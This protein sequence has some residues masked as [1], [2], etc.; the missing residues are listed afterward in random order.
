MRP[1]E[2]PP[3]GEAL[4]RA[5]AALAGR[6]YGVVSLA[7]LLE[8]GFSLGQVKRLVAAGR[9]HR[10]Y[11]GVY[12]VGHASLQPRGKLLAAVFACGG[13]AVASH[14]HAAWLWE[15]RRGWG[16]WIH[17][18][19]PER[20]RHAPA[21]IR[22]HRVRSLHPEDVAKV[23]GIPVTSVARTLF[24]L[25]DTLA[26]PQLPRAFDEAERRG[27]LDARAIERVCERAKGRRAVTLTRAALAEA[28]PNKPMTRSELEVA[29]VEFC[30]ECGFPPPSMNVWILGQEVD[31]AW[32]DRGVV[33]ELDSYEYHRTRR[34]FE[35]DRARSAAL[36]VAGIK[37]IR[38]TERRLARERATL[39]SQLCSLL[40][41]PG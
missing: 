40:A 35:E 9:L 25:S 31:A 13:A 33:V 38:V 15:L 36:T 41:V 22:L 39:R 5:L 37:T 12:A 18:T 1:K 28:H 17:V 11:R 3:R 34:A 30:R 16:R 29:F 26:L 14:Q 2:S 10:L 27:L 4:F 24:D 32:P 6:Q 7:Q 19:T 8:L 21:G 20:G 23:G